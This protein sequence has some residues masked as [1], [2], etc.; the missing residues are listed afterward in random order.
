LIVPKY[1]TR[2]LLLFHTLL[3]PGYSAFHIEKD[4]F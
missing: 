3:S 4:F 1:K 2:K